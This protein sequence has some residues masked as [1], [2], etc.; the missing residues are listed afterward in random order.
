MATEKNDIEINLKAKA[1]TRGFKEVT[2]GMKGLSRQAGSIG[3]SLSMLNGELG[4]ISGN[5]GKVAG[6]IADLAGM[7]K[8]GGMLAAGMAAVTLVIAGWVK[9]MQSAKEKAKELGTAIRDSVGREIEAVSARF[10][11]IFS[12]RD[13]ANRR[14]IFGSGING[15]K[16]KS[17]MEWRAALYE[18][19]MT[20]KIEAET[21][22]YKKRRL[23][24]QLTRGMGQYAAQNGVDSVS[25]NISQTKAL[26]A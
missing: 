2:D 10:S 6:S 16:T 19:Q 9:Y 21:D 4:K 20:A 5:A 3:K 13:A 7:L 11:N 22:P 1:D 17:D 26:L 15:Q 24:A 14:T 12:G 18:E 23:Q 25:N 8:G